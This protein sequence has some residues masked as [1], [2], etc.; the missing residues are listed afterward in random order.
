MMTLKGL[1]S[2]YNKDLQEDKEP[3]FDAVE[4]L[5]GALQIAHGVLATLTIH[6]A[7][8]KLA[9]SPEML[10]TDL[11][12]YLV[13]RGVPF[14]EAHHVAGAAVKMAEV[15]GIPL[16]ELALEDLQTL[17]SA[18]AADVEQVWHF[19]NSVEQRDA[20]G[21]ASRRA[22]AAQIAALESWLTV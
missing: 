7:H 14:R 21:G 4:S 2:T 20:D 18:F 15:Q 5:A 16:T 3:L 1:P 13:R 11:A 10:A 19:E 17:H 22:V 9:L 8:M 6:P 12:D